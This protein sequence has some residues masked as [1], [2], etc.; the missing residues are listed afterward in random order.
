M[1]LQP[2]V[3]PNFSPFRSTESRFRVTG[4]YETSA[5]KVNDPTITLNTKT[6][7]TKCQRYPIHVTT[8]LESQISHCFTLR[9]TISEILQI[10]HL[11]IGSQR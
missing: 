3:S 6:L 9:L 10:F 5:L 4:H 1:M 2:S 7:N 11:P 8:T